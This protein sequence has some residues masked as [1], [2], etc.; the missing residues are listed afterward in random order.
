MAIPFTKSYHS[1]NKT[2]LQ[3]TAEHLNLDIGGSMATLKEHIKQHIMDPTRLHNLITNEDYIHQIQ[4]HLSTTCISHPNTQSRF[5]RMGW[6]P[7]S[8]LD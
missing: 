1:M 2:E 3:E 4:K 8:I 7:I 5:P 6:H